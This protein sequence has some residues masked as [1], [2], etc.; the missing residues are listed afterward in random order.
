MKVESQLV[1]FPRVLLVPSKQRNEVVEVT[2]ICSS[3]LVSSW[4][5]SGPFVLARNVNFF[6]YSE[7]AFICISLAVIATV[8]LKSSIEE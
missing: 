7:Q 6:T 1:P 8:S 2:L 5:S 3:F 4:F